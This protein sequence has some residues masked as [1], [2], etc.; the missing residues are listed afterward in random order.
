M[1]EVQKDF[2]GS[3]DGYTVCEY[4]KGD[5][6]DLVPSLAEV[7]LKEKW[8][9]RAAARKAEAEVPAQSAPAM[10]AANTTPPAVPAPPVDSAVSPAPTVDAPAITTE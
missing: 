2:K 3:P 5:V 7:A 10:P 8:V 9:K 4:R 6:V 1:F